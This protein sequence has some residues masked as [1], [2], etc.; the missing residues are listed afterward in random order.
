M[1]AF[2]RSCFPGFYD[3]V[4]REHSDTN[5]AGCPS[6]LLV[7]PADSGKSSLVKSHFRSEKSHR[8]IEI[9]PSSLAVAAP[10][11][12]P[13]AIHRLFGRVE[14]ELRQCEQRD[15]TLVESASKDDRPIVLIVDDIHELFP[16]SEL[17][18]RAS[19][20]ISAAGASGGVD[21]SATYADAIRAWVRHVR[22]LSS[23]PVT[24]G[25]FTIVATARSAEAIASA[26]LATFKQVC[27]LTILKSA[28][29][30]AA[31]EAAAVH[32]GLCRGA[33]SLDHDVSSGDGILLENAGQAN[34]GIH[35][36][37]PADVRSLAI[38]HCTGYLIGD[39]VRVAN[40][41][42]AIV[43]GLLQ[44]RTLATT[45]GKV[46]T[47][48]ENRVCALSVLRSAIAGHVPST[49]LA[50]D[51]TAFQ[52][53]E[54]ASRLKGGNLSSGQGNRSSKRSGWVPPSN[55]PGLVDSADYSPSGGSGPVA[56]RD[57]SSVESFDSGDGGKRFYGWSGG[58]A[59]DDDESSNND[60]GGDDEG[61]FRSGGG[62]AVSS[63]VA[64]LLRPTP[65]NVSWSDIG[66]QEDAKRALHDL[67][68]WPLAH[69][70]AV[71][72]LGLHL[73]SGILLYGPPGTGKTL[74]AKA[75]ASHMGARFINISIPSVLRPGVGDSE[76]ALAS[77]FALARASAPCVVFLDEIQALLPSRSGSG[78]GGGGDDEGGRM[79]DLLTSTIMA[80]MDALNAPQPA[81]STSSRQHK[82][83]DSNKGYGGDDDVSDPFSKRVVVLAATNVPEALDSALLRPGR[84]D[85]AVFVGLPSTDERQAMIRRALG[86]MPVVYDS[87]SA[88]LE[89]SADLLTAA[90]VSGGASDASSLSVS[91]SWATQGYSGA[92]I[93]N[94]CRRAATLAVSEYVAGS[95]PMMDGRSATTVLQ[96]PPP[97]LPRHFWAAAQGMSPSCPPRRVEELRHWKPPGAGRGT[98]DASGKA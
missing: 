4:E 97:L 12:L 29:R 79:S 20:A 13:H 25:F 64:S 84:F 85:R 61:I 62:G 83:R 46:G 95:A 7:G 18:E 50:A 60:K 73:P 23:S 28:Q 59:G 44:R 36:A 76:R 87:S 70:D 33:N 37:L 27:A 3:A 16:S 2:P 41:A 22:R 78:S 51:A 43:S 58:A 75:I 34:S 24:A 30:A 35:H 6:L 81:A 42:A 55:L 90:A 10:G 54:G 88:S 71:R 8:V 31:L 26:I 9:D 17:K 14:R 39:I 40:S 86:R 45:Q 53:S 1:I 11:D 77:A 15:G 57:S 67:L 52:G 82:P 48:A 19:C 21:D 49:M 47:A 65:A 91:L 56:A 68:L 66:G 72:R 98:R 94:L 92:D 74:L 63:S 5:D 96:G 80:C 69:R 93:A 89:P 38:D 32:Y